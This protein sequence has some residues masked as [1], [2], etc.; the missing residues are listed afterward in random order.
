M[1]VDPS[2]SAAHPSPEAL[3]L[4]EI[5][6]PVLDEGRERLVQAARALRG[7]AMPFDPDA[8]E[9]LL[10]PGLARQ[11][12]GLLTRTVILE[13][14]VARLQG[15]LQGTTPQERFSSFMEHLGRPETANALLEE[16]PVL[17][18]KAR[19]HID[20]WVAASAAFLG[21]LQADWQLL[22]VGLLTD[23]GP[24]V[25]V[26]G[27]AGDSHRGGRGVLVACF[28]S[29]QRLV[30]KPRSL[31]I[32]AHFQEILSWVN[33]RGA[34]PDFRTLNVVDRGDHGWTEFVSQRD[35]TTA[36]E[37]KRFYERLGGHVALTH[38]LAGSDLHYENLV[39]AGEH[40]VLV[41][42]EVLFHPLPPGWS[43]RDPAE[44]AL[45]D[46]LL[47]TGLLPRVEFMEGGA[48][49]AD[50]SVL[51]A[52][53]GQ[54]SPAEE[55]CL[56][57]AGTDEVRLV[58]RR[59]QLSPGRHRPMLNGAEV[60]PLD[61]GSALTAG[62]TRTYQLLLEH[63][64]ELLA[65]GG[66]LERCADD[67]A[68][69]VVRP[70]RSYAILL[71]QS[72]HP[73]RLRDERE[74]E[75]LFD[76]LQAGI[77]HLP[78]L[79][80]LLPYERTELADG[81]VPLFTARPDS[82]DL[83][84]S[85]GERMPHFFEGSGLD[86]VRRRLETMGDADLARQ[87]STL[88]GALAILPRAAC[89]AGQSPYH[90]NE[91]RAAERE[92]LLEAARAVGDR[93][94]TLAWR[95]G[96]KAGWLGLTPVRE[97]R[98]GIAPLG[99]DLYDG[100]PGVTLFLAQFGAATGEDRYAALARSALL[101][102]R[103]R[104]KQ[105]DY[106]LRSIGAF[107]GWGGVIHLLTRLAILWNEPDFLTEAA[108]AVE[109]LTPLIDRDEDLDV[110][111]GAAGCLLCLLGLYRFLPSPH[112]LAAAIRCGEH[113]L[114]RAV[115]RQEGAAW[116]TRLPASAPLTGL[117]HG[118]AGIAWALIELAAVTGD[119]RFQTAGLDGLRYER[120]QFDPKEGNW[121]DF[122]TKAH[123]AGTSRCFEV[124][125][126][127]GAPGIALTRLRLLRHD[128][129]E[130]AAL[131]EEIRA[132]VTTTC[133]RGFDFN[134][135]LCHGTLGNAEV[136]LEAGRVLGEQDWLD[137]ARLWAGRVLD[138]IRAGGWQ[139]ATPGGAESPGLMTGLAGIGYA[140]LRLAEPERVP[141]V[142]S[143]SLTAD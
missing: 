37:V 132:A 6:R 103:R 67:E 97:E 70:T 123:D 60:D 141:S 43:Q 48:E 40:P 111:G 131:Q 3:R 143:L 51:G 86:R 138:G 133:S 23:P 25:E 76:H 81:D 65:S 27:G 100:L 125:W 134:H 121:P 63:R 35:C 105:T 42:L 32:D 87:L 127:H 120:S 46:S 106:P 11:L 17:A 66:L 5:L 96:E 130:T 77:A 78:I 139:C 119:A 88:R 53:S 95:A 126:C 1:K 19:R 28:A 38:T 115:P 73:D 9:S 30:Y 135:S 54:L 52:A 109:G 71:Q 142:L 75:R 116:K 50:I 13:L 128:A 41:D 68:R 104:L 16:Y 4:L 18:R 34:Q 64:A 136:V 114:V 61:H 45:A 98:W 62:F 55:F 129:G 10:F 90:G 91:G 7:P 102:L 99:V 8:V 74:Q 72:N 12:L 82:L 29:G 117:S 49:G 44:Q 14:H 79:A 20:N 137:T 22:Q 110:I 93:L 80:C 24:L 89:E 33:E 85:T 92:E 122:R 101:G 58:R 57:G 124:A 21:H 83:W 31:A 56:E 107:E 2:S 113:L 108:A 36:D 59:V 15:L 47:G 94:N 39:A 26:S 140:F 84:S 118:A 112:V 69:Y